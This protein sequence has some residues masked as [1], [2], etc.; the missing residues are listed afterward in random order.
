MSHKSTF[1]F[2]ATA[3][4]IASLAIP[5]TASAHQAPSPQTVVKH[6][7]N[8]DQ[9][10]DKVASLVAHN[11]DAAAAI[12]LAR[13]RRETRDASREA[14]RLAKRRGK[15]GLRRAAA[16]TRT[17]AKLH[18][19]N[20]EVLAGIVDEAGAALALDIAMAV[21]ADLRARDNALSVL[22]RLMERLPAEA[23]EG[24]AR[25][26]AAVSGTVTMRSPRSSRHFRAA[27]FRPRPPRPCSGRSR[28]LSR[29]S[30]RGLSGC[31]RSSTRYRRRYVPIWRWRRVSSSRSGRCCRTCWAAVFR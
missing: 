16:V 2:A 30:I 20:A 24:I 27:T 10:L 5:A 31:A 26:L 8:A 28:V 19:Q 29:G 4:A 15:A 13:N 22:T 3:A 6:A 25:A 23:Q 7:R 12:A 21:D 18:D 17:V 9:A 11:R 14:G 1:H